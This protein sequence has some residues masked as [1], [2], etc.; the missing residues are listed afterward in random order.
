LF[1]VRGG[2]SR[3][4]LQWDGFRA[5]EARVFFAKVISHARGGVSAVCLLASVIGASAAPAQEAR[6]FAGLDA[7]AGLRLA[8]LIASKVD[9]GMVMTV[10]A[11]GSM[12]PTFDETT[13]LVLEPAAFS[14]LRVGDVITYRHPWLRQV[15]VHRIVEAHD[16]AFLTKGDHND[17]PDN[18][19]VTRENFLMRVVTVVHCR[20]DV[21]QALTRRPVPRLEQLVARHVD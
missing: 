4:R 13:L 3:R 1:P 19:E 12:R 20:E 7:D 11:T 17:R 5:E 16:G 15:I 8:R 9:G 6:P 18:V 10:A 2:R 14:E 21:L